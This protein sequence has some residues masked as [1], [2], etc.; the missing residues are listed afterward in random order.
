MRC[1]VRAALEDWL[2]GIELPWSW[3]CYPYNNTNHTISVYPPWEI[4]AG[5]YCTL[6]LYVLLWPHGA[7]LYSD[8]GGRSINYEYADPEFPN[9]LLADLLATIERLHGG[10]NEPAIQNS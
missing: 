7:T 1:V 3:F 4:D 9:N 10:N 2:R 8:F 6:G 5:A